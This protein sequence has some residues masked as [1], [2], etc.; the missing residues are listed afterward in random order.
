MA[1]VRI[2]IVG[3]RSYTARELLVRLVGHPAAEVVSLMAR[4]DEPLD[5][6][7]VHPTLRDR[8]DLKVIPIDEARLAEECEL[9]FLCMPHGPAAG[10]AQGLIEAGRRVVDFSADF[11]FADAAIYERA[12][13]QAHAALA[14]LPEAVYGLPELWR[15]EVRPA[16]VVGNPGCYPTAVLLAL[17]PLTRAFPDALPA[18]GI[19]ADCKSGVSGMGRA[20]AERAHFGEAN[21]GL[22][23]YNV[24]IH[25]HSPEID[26]Q[27]AAWAGSPRHVTFAPHLVPM[28]RGICA[29]VHIPWRGTMPPLETIHATFEEVCRRE[30]FLRLMA[31]GEMVNTKAVAH[32]NFVD[33]A[34]ASDPEA[35]LLIVMAVIDNLVKGASGQAVQNMNLMIG[36]EETAGLL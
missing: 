9:V 12:Y 35:N 2:G 5:V 28:D 13:G 20:L 29:T 3:A 4:L 31:L 22:A 24:A 18:T 11:R 32:T 23:P 15:D 6:G 10:F 25:R 30:P 34:V 21:E 33:L 26:T 19:V 7:D 8:C 17:A 16:R 1:K 27:L 14:L 36:C